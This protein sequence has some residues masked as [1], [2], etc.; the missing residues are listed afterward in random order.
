MLLQFDQ[1]TLAYMT[2]ALEQVCK[3]IPPEI[4]SNALRKRIADEMI[5]SARAYRRTFPD[6]EE[7]GLK[8]LN[9]MR[10]PSQL[11]WLLQ[12]LSISS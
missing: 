3:K 8:V 5:A 11:D 6:F 4:D 1:S 9:E 10:P 2:A 7:A 12:K